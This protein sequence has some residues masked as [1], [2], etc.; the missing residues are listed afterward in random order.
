MNIDIEQSIKN[1]C[2]NKKKK[3]KWTSDIDGLK[4]FVAK[5][6]NEQDGTWRSPGGGSWSFANDS[7]TVTWYTT[8]KSIQF[9][10]CKGKAITEMI[11]KVCEEVDESLSPPS[12]E[13]NAGCHLQ[14]GHREV[15]MN[16]EDVGAFVAEELNE[17][18]T[19]SAQRSRR[20]DSLNYDHTNIIDQQD[21][22]CADDMKE[23][24]EEECTCKN[25]R[26]LTIEMAETKLDITMLGQR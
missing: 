18:T 2:E 19:T 14:N 24:D 11:T 16:E 7:L 9:Q 25:C 22:F 5:K 3:L 12:E 6:L 15:D 23:Y 8:S 13:D 26:T 17:C 1:L 20:Q 21:L 10:G 4:S